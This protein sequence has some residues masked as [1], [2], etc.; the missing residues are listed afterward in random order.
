MNG[1]DLIVDGG[2]LV[3]GLDDNSG[4]RWGHTVG[5]KLFVWRSGIGIDA[6]SSSTNCCAPCAYMAS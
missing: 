4:N 6:R 2:K 1:I 5:N 3:A